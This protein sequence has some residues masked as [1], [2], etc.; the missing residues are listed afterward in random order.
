MLPVPVL[1]T[2]THV[3]RGPEA[4]VPEPPIEP[5]LP[6]V[7]GVCAVVA[8]SGSGAASVRACLFT[9]YSKNVTVAQLIDLRSISKENNN[10]NTNS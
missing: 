1:P 4:P 8:E 2:V 7:P 6:P 5:V 10:G 9:P 3:F